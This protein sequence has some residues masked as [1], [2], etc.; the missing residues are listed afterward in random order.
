MPYSDLQY[1]GETQWLQLLLPLPLA[2][3]LCGP[4]AHPLWL[5][6]LT[7]SPTAVLPQVESEGSE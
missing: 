7:G 3:F 1:K 6:K 4:Q 5:I 2:F